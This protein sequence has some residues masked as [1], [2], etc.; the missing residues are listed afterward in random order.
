MVPTCPLFPLGENSHCPGSSQGT[1]PPQRCT[2]R[3]DEKLY[4]VYTSAHVCFYKLDVC[5]VCV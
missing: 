3:K 4:V 5:V 1:A 2:G